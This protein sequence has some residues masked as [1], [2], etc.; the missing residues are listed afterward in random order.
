M[1][2]KLSAPGFLKSHILPVLVST[3]ALS[4]FS[5]REE[6]AEFSASRGTSNKTHT[7]VANDQL[8]AKED[9]QTRQN[10]AAPEI[11]KGVY[12]VVSNVE[13]FVETDISLG[14]HLED[15]AD[16]DFNDLVIC[17]QGKFRYSADN[18][19]VVSLEDQVNEALINRLSANQIN[20]IG[21]LSH[22]D[23]TMEQIFDL[24]PN[25][26]QAEKIEIHWMKD[27]KLAVDY[28][29]GSWRTRYNLSTPKKIKFE[30]DICRTTGI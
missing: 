19:T 5:C 20:V 4:M 24:T 17:L 9:S 21:S 2:P 7:R 22:L 13:E 23:G 11:V 12:D 29:V 3:T 8:A 10:N 26:D 30:A 15:A 28:K 16:N 6:T 25:F 1:H 14:I 27:T 18:G